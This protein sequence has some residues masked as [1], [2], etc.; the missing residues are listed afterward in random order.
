VTFSDHL[1]LAVVRRGDGEVVLELEADQRHLNRV[2]VV[3]GGV[4]ASMADTAIGLAV[5][6]LI[7]LET[8]MTLAAQLNV[9][10]IRAA[11]T[12][13]L[14]ARG[15]VTSLGR[16]IAFGEAE[17]YQGEALVAKATGVVYIRPR[18]ADAGR[19]GVSPARQAGLGRPS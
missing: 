2:G 18:Q 5:Q 9:N 6:T 12:G 15:V 1:G 16:R 8:H 7:D 3:H 13:L 14:T 10:F 4:L 11:H 17:V 19:A